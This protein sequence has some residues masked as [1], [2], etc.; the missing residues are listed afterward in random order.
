MFSRVL[1]VHEEGSHTAG[2]EKKRKK[3]SKTPQPG[4]GRKAQRSVVIT[5]DPRRLDRTT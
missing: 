2:G 4:P 5:R 3:Q 1:R